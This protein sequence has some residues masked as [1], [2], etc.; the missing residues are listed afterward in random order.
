MV[1]RWPC[2]RRSVIETLQNLGLV[3]FLVGGAVVLSLL[4]ALKSRRGLLGS[5][6]SA[7]GTALQ[8][9]FVVGTHLVAALDARMA[10]A[11]R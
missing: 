11:F 4:G 6:A 7:V 10:P 3:D 5:L 8:L 1:F 9:V 2:H